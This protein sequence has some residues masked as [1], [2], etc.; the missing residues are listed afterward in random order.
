MRSADAHD[1]KTTGVF[2]DF[3][4]PVFQGDPHAKYLEMIEKCPFHREPDLGWHAVF[5]HA[6]IIEIVRD[7]ESFSVR[8]GPGT[9]YV[10]ENTV[11]VLVGADPPL[12]TKQKKALAPAFNPALIEALREPI[13]AFVA[14][15]FEAMA[16]LQTLDL[17]EEL[18][19]Q[20]P[21]FVICRL[22]D[23]PFADY[24]RL[25]EWVDVLAGATLQKAQTME[26]DRVEKVML[27]MQYFLPRI[28]AKIAIDEAGG[29]PGEDMIALLVK[30]RID[31]ERIPTAQILG[32]AQFLLVAGAATTTVFIGS[33]FNLMIEHPDQWQRLKDNP[34]LIDTALEETLRLESPVHGLFRTNRCPMDLGGTPIEAD[35]KIGLM[36]FAGNLDPAVFEN[37]LAFDIAREPKTLRKHLSFGHG[38]HTCIG[39]PLARMEG[40]VVV[41]EFMKRF[42]GL[43][44]A[45]PEVPYPYPTLNGPYKLPVWLVAK[46]V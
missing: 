34:A 1:T 39:G 41:E 3:Y 30:G 36:W 44:R 17:M 13:R 6:D 32:F 27:M 18:A 5:R 24:P 28:E 43:E 22:L 20:V 19:D 10:D 26:A 8:H 2:F 21:M 7:N 37:P 40:K 16:G 42:E 35:T 15:R 4:D 38:L 23:L 12:H 29:N 11:P 9:A 31:G 33:F 25:R 46:P 45:G 14:E